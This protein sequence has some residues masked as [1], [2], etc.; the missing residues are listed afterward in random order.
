MQIG[1]SQ[2]STLALLAGWGLFLQACQSSLD[3][4]EDFDTAVANAHLDDIRLAR[5]ASGFTFE[6]TGESAFEIAALG[7]QAQTGQAGVV[8][9]LWALSAKDTLVRLAEGITSGAG[10]WSP[11]L[12]LPKDIDS[13][14]LR[15]RTPG[16]PQEH[17]VAVS[18]TGTTRY[19]VGRANANGRILPD[20]RVDQP[21]WDYSGLTALAGG[22]A[23]LTGRAGFQYMG[24][25][26]K[27]GVPNYLT[28]PV[29]IY[30]DVLGFIATNLPENSVEV[31]HPEFLNP[32]YSSTLRFVNAGE[33]WISFAHEGSGTLNA[34]G[35]FLFDLNQEPKR[36]KDV[37]TFTIAY[38][39]VS[40][41]G[42]GGGLKVSNRIYLGKVPANTGVCFFLVPNGWN[43][44]QQRVVSKPST[45]YTI[46]A[47]NTFT[48]AEYRRHAILLANSPRE[49][50]V[51]GFE[52]LNRPGADSD[53]ND[54]IFIVEPKPWSAVDL[55]RT[56]P[57]D[58]SGFD[59]DVD[60]IPD[61]QD[62]FPTDNL[63]AFR[64]FAPGEGVYGT[65]AYE[66]MW[67]RTGDYD[68]NDLVVDYNVTEVLAPDNRVKD[69][70]I[71][72]ALRALGATQNHGFAFRL[73]V[74]PE[75]IEKVSGQSLVGNTYF[76]LNANG[77]EAGQRTAVV[78][79]F[80]NSWQVL[81]TRFGLINTDRDKPQQKA[82]QQELVVT[83]KTPIARG[84]LGRPPYDAFLVR[85]QDRSIEI[86]MAGY[87]PT[88]KADRTL[89]GTE[90]DKSDPATGYWYVDK[91]NLPWG[92][93]LPESFR[94][95]KEKKRIDEVYT[96][97]VAW[98]VFGGDTQAGWY[99]DI[100]T[101]VNGDNAF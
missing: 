12:S 2:R 25:F 24:T 71:S 74:A 16:F 99:H 97:F 59:R 92:V 62:A 29:T 23:G 93:H 67:P 20:A 56:P 4:I 35:Y 33:A 96:S 79:A 19:T 72:L 69:L 3:R 48:T 1:L 73:P 32:K 66:D 14:T 64:S 57:A 85:S 78:P 47:L 98:A 94:Y 44:S 52:D 49:V 9:S 65:L 90:A 51:L 63:R 50:L 10:T 58:V 43:A 8:V 87:A 31:F 75:L 11:T 27:L 83:F 26:N 76:D 41:E 101:N 13:V 22:D 86:H 6:T 34:V 7:S 45:R 80:A 30:P 89:F 82:Y 17:R 88:D 95:P 100:G 77:T 39:N 18:S 46:D 36:T 40:F 42:S 84:M 28:A 53:F 15:V 60:G 5:A 91:N 37:P 21:D 54:A 38:P 61:Y 68:F 70:R 55:T 81:N